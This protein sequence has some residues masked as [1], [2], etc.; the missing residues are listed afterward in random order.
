MHGAR[1][2]GA[3][4]LGVAL[5][6]T[7]VA[8]LP[9]PPLAWVLGSSNLPTP[10]VAHAGVSK[11]IMDRL[12]RVVRDNSATT[13]TL[14]AMEQH[15]EDLG[16]EMREGDKKVER[17]AVNVQGVFDD[18]IVHMSEWCRGVLATLRPWRPR[19]RWYQLVALYHPV[20]LDGGRVKT[21]PRQRGMG[22][23]YAPQVFGISGLQA[24]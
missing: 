11:E 8:W 9:R 5:L 20:A 2:P 16:K 23:L 4:H 7:D 24:C 12:D 10:G 15:L 13:R 3:L 21:C 14:Q 18:V 17:I 22:Y 1:W 6:S 19:E